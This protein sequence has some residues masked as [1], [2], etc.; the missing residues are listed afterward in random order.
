MKEQK[1][2]I[3]VHM[4]TDFSDGSRGTKEARAIVPASAAPISACREDG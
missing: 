2:L 3:V 4:Q 1:F